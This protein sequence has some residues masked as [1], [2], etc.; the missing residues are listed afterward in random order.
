MPRYC[1]YCTE[2]FPTAAKLAEHLKFSLCST[3][4]DVKKCPYCDRDD[5]VDQD[6][7]NRHLSHNRRCSRADVEA[8]DKLSIIAPDPYYDGTRT[9]A[10]KSGDN[11]SV[12]NRVSYVDV[13][14]Q[15]QGNLVNIA[16]AM[17]MQARNQMQ[18]SLH[19]DP[20]SLTLL[21]T[22]A[23]DGDGYDGVVERQLKSVEKLISS[24]SKVNVLIL[25][26]DNSAESEH[27][28]NEH[29]LDGTSGFTAEES[30]EPAE[31]GGDHDSSQSRA[32]PPH[33]YIEF[34]VGD[35]EDDAESQETLGNFRN[36]TNIF[37]E[38][39]KNV[40]IVENFHGG[41]P[42]LNC[43]AELYTMLDKRGVANS[44][45][46]EIA[47]WAW[48]N[49]STF[50]RTPP[51]R[52]NVVVE[53]VFRHV[54]GENYKQYMAPRQ[55][56]LKLSTGRHVAVTYFPLE[57][58]IKDMLCNSALMRRDHLLL[59]D[60]DGPGNN[61]P[62][63]RM[64]T[65]GDVNTGSWWKTATET[66]CTKN[67]DLLWPLIMF[68]D[69][70]KVDNHSG[71]LKLEP[72]SFTFSR[73]CRW[74]RNQDNAWRTW[75]YMEEVKQPRMVHDNDDSNDLT[76]KDRLQEY[77]DILRFLMRDLKKIQ[78]EGFPWILDVGDGMK[79]NVVLKMPIQF[80]IGD[81]EGHDKLVGRFKGHTMNI[82]GLCRDC[83]IPTRHSD[84]VDWLCTYFVDEVMKTLTAEQLRQLSFHSIEN[85]FNG[86]SVGGCPRGIRTLFNP[87]MLH[88]FKAGQCEWIFDG[89]IF[90]LSSK[91]EKSS[92]TA[93]A[94][95]VLMNRGQSDRSYP[96][97]GTFRDGMVKP[98]GI[99]LAGH[100]KHARLFFMYLLLCCSDYVSML[101]SNP[102]RGHPYN[103]R[104]YRCFLKLL[105][106]SLGFYEWSNKCEHD[107]D[108]I[109]GPDGTPE[110]S[111]SQESVRRYLSL[112]KTICPREEMGKNF[113]M[114]KFHQSL[115]LV[116]TIA[117]HGSL[118]NVDGSRPESMAKLNVKDPASHTQR[119]SSTLSY[120]TGK[121]YIESLTFREY[122]RLRA[123]ETD[124]PVNC[125]EFGQYL[126]SNTQAANRQR[127]SHVVMN[128]TG[129]PNEPSVVTTG[130]K[131]SIVLD[132]D[133]RE[134]EFSVELHWDASVS[135]P[136]IV[137]FDKHIL[138]QLGKRLFGAEDGGVIVDT[139]VEGCTAVEVNGCL[140]QAHPLFRKDHPWFDWVYIKWD[141]Y[142]LPF[143]ARIE[144]FFDLRKA[145]IS[146]VRLNT[147]DDHSVSSEEDAPASFD[148]V[149]LENKVY[150]VVW[151][152]RSLDFPRE[153]LTD[154]HLPLQLAYRVQ[155]ERYRRI[156]EVE[157]FLR[158]C[159][160]FLNTCGLSEGGPFDQ[161]A[162]ILKDRCQWEDHFLSVDRRL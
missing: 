88:L 53:K 85:G 99:N 14:P 33:A 154:K 109:L 126:N 58:M 142:D 147:S 131:F 31:Q 55:K 120:Q 94:Y 36:E 75:A 56:I 133:Q 146:N 123:E 125:C 46:D 143:P 135:K 25:Q 78:E 119:V 68:I 79:H 93:S 40:P 61:P 104:F 5:F 7:L 106:H 112:M 34:D 65:F 17:E 159:F 161:T 13:L 73:F 10:G 121:R 16:N 69:G 81:C 97:I 39:M 114:T 83:D 107:S 62:N 12:M 74:I 141:G 155:L 3:H 95:F 89:Y 91:A 103:L 160:G 70:M 98:Q 38:A 110:T 82:K 63:E 134:N 71:K 45:F 9:D 113:K 35:E 23:D 129:L 47:Q 122:K 11:S 138:Q 19:P 108:S 27:H 124:E 49:G 52:R 132:L 157:S 92:K 64:S 44:L 57:N 77:H 117:R 37:E 139:E 149:F 72:I 115:H 66:E 60:V 102:K 54:R 151:S 50:G 30:E 41:S 87:E 150:A 156:V 158:P 130:S 42:Q 145:T 1:N 105:E 80:I 15:L 128:N 100:E 24:E 51:M 111:Q 116:D 21:V 59:D 86:I 43:L 152:A 84:D 90:T 2:E 26:N 48:L 153:S 96:E 136:N 8:T 148:H 32:T 137:K 144:M 28:H 29:D 6:S 4:V 20:S 76:A 67:H 101:S 127:S 162:V 22:L 118:L 18:T 140:Y